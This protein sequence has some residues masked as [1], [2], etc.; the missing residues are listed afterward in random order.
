LSKTKTTKK[1]KPFELVNIYEEEAIKPFL[2]K[3]HNPNYELHYIDIPFRMLIIGSSGSGKTLTLYNILR[4]FSG[5]FQNIHIIAKSIDE[6]IYKYIEDRFKKINEHPK[7]KSKLNV[8]VLEGMN[9]LPDLA[10]FNKDEQSLVVLDDLVLEKNQS[11]IEEY[12]IRCRKLNVSVIYISQSYYAIPKIIRQNVSY[13]IV[14]QV[15]SSKNL[16]LIA[17]EYSL[18]LDS[19]QLNQVYNFCTR[20][21]SDFMLIDIDHK[22]IRFRKNF[23][24]VIDI[25]ELQN[26][27]GLFNAFKFK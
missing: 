24:F 23:T 13:L 10:S 16:K 11:K 7:A 5:T 26:K 17:N 4:I 15:S 18:G 14:K 12:Y 6:P 9:S 2:L 8:N 20:E 1:N 3:S 22:D 19:K 25:N 21:K 27:S